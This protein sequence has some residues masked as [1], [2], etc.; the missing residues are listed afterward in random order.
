MF[1]NREEYRA[2]L[3]GCKLFLDKNDKGLCP[4]EQSLGAIKSG[5]SFLPGT[6]CQI[7]CGFLF[8][9][10]LDMLDSAYC[11]CSIAMGKPCD[12]IDNFEDREDFIRGLISTRVEKK[13]KE[14]LN[15]YNKIYNKKKIKPTRPKFY[16]A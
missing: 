15:V 10:I 14:V 2:F 12:D 16:V 7:F 5:R 6:D 11:P 13:Y 1:K 8:P 4:F 3:N 9:E